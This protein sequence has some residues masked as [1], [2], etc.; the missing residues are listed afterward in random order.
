MEQQTRVLVV[1]DDPLLQ[2]KICSQILALRGMTLG[3]SFSSRSAA[4]AWIERHPVDLLLTDIGLPDGSGLD[5][6]RACAT[7]Q[8]GCEILVITT[9]GDEASI[10]AAIDAG[11]RG[12]ILKKSG[13]LDIARFFSELKQGGSPMSPLIA[14]KLLLRAVGSGP[15]DHP[16]QGGRARL[17]ALTA[18]ELQALNF[19][20]RGYTYEEISEKM[21]ISLSTVQSHIKSTYSKLSVHS[22]GAAVYEANRLGLFDR[23]WAGRL[24]PAGR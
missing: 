1:E 8:P 15:S 23:Q 10:L 11:A 17:E 2:E 14:R 13:P 20:A 7:L 22:R 21:H 19:I 6:I 18:R 4:V 9:Y 5:V 3:A 12:Y 16:V 24:E